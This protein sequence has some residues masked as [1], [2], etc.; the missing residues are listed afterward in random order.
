MQRV[1]LWG[2]STLNEM[3]VPN[4]LPG[5]SG[6]EG[7]GKLK[8]PKVV[9]DC[10]EGA[11]SRHRTKAR[12]KLTETVT[13]GKM[14]TMSLLAGEKKNHFVCLFVCLFQKS[15]TRYIN[16]ILGQAPCPDFVG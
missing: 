8:E 2:H 14:D 1:R 5:D 3:S 6:G 13:P 12:Y 10:K 11:S 4:S 7:S 16:H 9:A 15:N